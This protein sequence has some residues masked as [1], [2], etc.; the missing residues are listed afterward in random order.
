VI[1]FLRGRWDGGPTLL[2]EFPDLVR[3]ETNVRSIG[4]GESSEMSPQD[5]IAAASAATPASPTGVASGD[6]Q[7]LEV[8][9]S[10]T[11]SPDVDGGEQPVSGTIRH[12]TSET[13]VVDRH[14]K[15]IGALSV[16]FPR[17][18]YRVVVV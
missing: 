1:W 10:V 6:P 9:M 12:A 14:D 11:V 5:A 4:H 16:H 13:I 2:S 15:D 18:G 8:G 7:G 3:W 17:F